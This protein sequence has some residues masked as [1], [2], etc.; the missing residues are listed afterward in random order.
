VEQE[1]VPSYY[2]HRDEVFD[3][4]KRAHISTGHGGRDKMMK[5]LLPKYANITRDIIGILQG[6]M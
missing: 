5:A 4:V 6:P 3:M 1:A 2:I